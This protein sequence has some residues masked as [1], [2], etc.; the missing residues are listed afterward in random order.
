VSVGRFNRFGLPSPAAT[1][2]YDEK[3]I[4]LLRTDQAG[5]VTVA[6]DGQ[7]GL[8]VVCQRGCGGHGPDGNRRRTGGR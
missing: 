6:I 2:R 4:D 1:A 5:A 7:G 8:R 3:A